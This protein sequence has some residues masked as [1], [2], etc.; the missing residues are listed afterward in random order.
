MEGTRPIHRFTAF[1]TA[2]LGVVVIAAAALGAV[3]LLARVENQP[4]RA[5]DPTVSI[6]D[7]AFEP[8]TVT[9]NADTTV[10]W[11]VSRARDPHTVS[12]V[13]PRTPTSARSIRRTCGEP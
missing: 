7:F 13:D 5:A 2:P 4:A 6:V 9:V 1:G 3:V 8:A 12:P 10:T 11:T